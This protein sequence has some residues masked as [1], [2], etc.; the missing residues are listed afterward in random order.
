[1]TNELLNTTGKRIK[2]L[3]N[4]K[5]LTQAGLGLLVGVGQIHVNRIET[6]A[7]VAGRDLL[8]AIAR[9]LGTTVSFL[10][11][12]TDDPAPPRAERDPVYFSAE[13]DE[14]A[15]IIDAMP[16][17]ARALSL[18]LLRVLSEHVLQ[19]RQDAPAI[20]VS[21]AN[22]VVRKVYERTLQGGAG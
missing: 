15:R 19:A 8:Q 20:G 3:R 18:N 6:G 10:L 22:L 5:G 12:E 4:D 2:A 14:A 7:R 9:E 16:E 13:A 11:L 17:H 1:M 21:G